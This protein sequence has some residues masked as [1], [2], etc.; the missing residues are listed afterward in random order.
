[1]PCD[2]VLLEGLFLVDE[3]MLTGES[4][5]VVK[6]F[7]PPSEGFYYHK[8]KK[9]T[10][11]AGTLPTISRDRVVGMVI[12]TGFF[13]AKGELVRSIL[14]PKPNRFSFYADSFKFV[15][16]LGC[17]AVIGFVWSTL[18]LVD[19]GDDTVDIILRSL[20]LVTIVVPPVLPL[21]MTIGTSFS[22][23]RLQQLKITCISLPAVNAAGRVSVVCF[24]KTGTITEDSMILKGVHCTELINPLEASY[25]FQENMGTCNSL[26]FIRNNIQGDPQEIAIFHST[27]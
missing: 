24:D 1:M 5:L 26:T 17:I 11:S 8:D 12:A 21:V 4:Q 14:F 13:T 7:M 18:V 15:G 16:I 23:F 2:V 25:E 6:E 19:S 3:S 10:M 9:Y 22:I 20:D 27:N